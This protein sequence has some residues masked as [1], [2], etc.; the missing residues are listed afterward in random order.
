MVA[1]VI[2]FTESDNTTAIDDNTHPDNIGQ[3]QA[4]SQSSEKEVHIWNNKAGSSNVSTAENVRVTT[5]TLS[6]Y[7][8]GDTVANGKE[9][10]ENKMV[11]IKSLTNGDAEFTAV[12][13]ATTKTLA[14]ISGTKVASP[15]TPLTNL[16]I[17]ENGA[18]IPNHYYIKISAVDETGETLPSTEADCGAW[19]YSNE[20]TTDTASGEV[21]STTTNTK[22][23]WKFT[24]DENGISVIGLKM[25]T[26]GTLVGSIRIETDNSGSPSGT[27]AHANGTVSGITLIEDTLT[28]IFFSMFCPLTPATTYWVVFTVNNGTGSLKGNASGT[29]VNT[30]Y[31]DGSWHNSSALYDLCVYTT[32]YN[33][34]EY[35]W[36]LT[37]GATSYK[38]FRTTT[39]GVYGASSLVEK[40]VKESPYIDIL[41]I[42]IAGEPLVT[43]T[44]TYGHNHLIKRRLD[45]STNATPGQADCYVELRYT[46]V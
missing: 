10:V 5:V 39:S 38:I 18:V 19:N 1:P 7:D 2:T 3:L 14:S 21:L 30:K 34:L 20:L 37:A 12:G 24:T 4:G 44:N 17:D 45:A 15:S 23:A 25:A 26:G 42:T 22:M 43:A 16:T 27:L 41:D 9:I 35:T 29:T 32:Y 28:D 6:G 8:S 36:T 33:A 46:Y 40:E 31:Y 13:G 11:K